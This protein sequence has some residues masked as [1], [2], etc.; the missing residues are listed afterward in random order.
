MVFHDHVCKNIDRIMMDRVLQHMDMV[1][2]KP[3]ASAVCGGML[4]NI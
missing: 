2:T 1:S 3:R 4:I